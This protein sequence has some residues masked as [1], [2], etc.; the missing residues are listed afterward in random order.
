MNIRIDEKGKRL[1]E[2]SKGDT[3]VFVDDSGATTDETVVDV[4][5][6]FREVYTER[7]ALFVETDY[8]SFEVKKEKKVYELTPSDVITNNSKGRVYD[9]PKLTKDERWDVEREV[10]EMCHQAQDWDQ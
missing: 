4:N 5:T 7:I 2:I 3:L 10:R 6:F 8:S 9:T 1:E